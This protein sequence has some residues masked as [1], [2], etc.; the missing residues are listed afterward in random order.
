VLP[1]GVTTT[2]AGGGTIAVAGT[3]TMT[4]PITN[5]GA[6]L[7][8]GAAANANGTI[9]FRGAETNSVGA[10]IKVVSGQLNMQADGGLVGG[11]ANLTLAVSDHAV[12]GGGTFV[13]A[14]ENLGTLSI[15]GG[16]VV[17]LNSSGPGAMPN[18]LLHTGT[19]SIKN[20][21]LPTGTLDMAADDAIVDNGV[22]AT[23]QAQVKSGYAGGT[24]NGP[25]IRSSQAAGKPA[26]LAGIG[27]ASVS[28]IGTTTFDG[29]SGLAPTAVL[30]KYTLLGDANLDGTVNGLDFNA[31]ATNYGQGA[32]TWADGD[33]NYSSDGTIDSND[34]ALLAANYG[35]SVATSGADIPDA[36]P[37]ALGALVPE[38][39]SLSLIAL[40]SIPMIRR[41]RRI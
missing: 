9:T 39:T 14:T 30:L 10:E 6:E 12:I 5:N 35:K 11:V 38:P 29:V 17:R 32:K 21:A 27:Y 24:W 3:L 37:V 28:Q 31:L 25:G 20:D 19:L 22:F 7:D 1:S 8:L 34:F 41:R 4:G 15:L 33:F 23:I 26:G 18:I 2:Y 36:A 40:A 13:N 16:G